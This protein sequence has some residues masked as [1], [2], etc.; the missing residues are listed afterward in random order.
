MGQHAPRFE[1]RHAC[2]ERRRLGAEGIRLGDC[3]L[4]RGLERANRDT[5]LLTCGAEG[6]VPWGVPS[7][8]PS[9]VPTQLC[10]TEQYE[11]DETEE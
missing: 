8:V 4:V 7:G 10:A 6:G 11:E 1:S 2:A 9:G 5:Q 3:L